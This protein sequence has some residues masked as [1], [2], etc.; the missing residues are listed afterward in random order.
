M[1][2]KILLDEYGF[3]VA[4]PSICK[5]G[6]TSYVVISREAE[7]LV[8]EIHDHK[9][10]LRSSNE[11]IAYI[12]SRISERWTL[13]R[14][15]K[16]FAQQGNLCQLFQQSASKSILV[17]TKNHSNKWEKME[18][19]S[20]SFTRWRIL[21]N[22]CIQDGY[23]NAASLWSRRKTKPTAQDIGIQLDQHL[24]KRVHEKRH[25]ILMM[26][27][28]WCWFMKEVTEGVWSFARTAMDLFVFCELFNDTLVVFQ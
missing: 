2:W 15:K 11:L 23:K 24:W 5:R 1:L 27:I 18:G 21:S 28:G 7:R 10:E 16:K 3:E 26:N 4:I 12:T 25:E 6:G 14:K 17:H 8:N 20:R 22:C 19:H 13:W 9:E